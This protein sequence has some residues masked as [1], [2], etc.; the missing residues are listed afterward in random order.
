MSNSVIAKRY[1]VALFQLGQEK[2][3]LDR[4]E[5]ELLTVRNVFQEND[6]LLPFFKHPRIDADKKKKV[7][8][9]AFQK[10][11]PEVTHTLHLFIDRHREE[12]IPSFIDRFVE[13]TNE[14]RGIAEADVYTARELKE[15]EAS[16]LQEVFAKKLNKKSLRIR[17]VIDPTLLGGVKLKI[18]NRIYDGSVSG[19]LAR[20][21]RN[22]VSA[23]K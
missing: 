9:D 18:G 7:L 15:E 19:K 22:L 5:E 14:A 23:N 6:Q 11:S 4:L 2:S 16:A 21:E 13:M 8:S 10:F 1:A 17:T 20:I 3:I 12:V